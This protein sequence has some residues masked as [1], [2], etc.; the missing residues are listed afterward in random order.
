M[1][2]GQYHWVAALCPPST[3][4]AA[5]WATGW[6]S[7]GGQIVLT[8]SAAFAAGLQAQALITLNH[9]DTYTPQRWQGMLF[10]WAILAYAGVLNIWGMKAMPHVNLVSGEFTGRRSEFEQPSC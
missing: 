7:V 3:R 5:S 1:T 4:S 8:A 6:I 10:Y 2:I 9:P